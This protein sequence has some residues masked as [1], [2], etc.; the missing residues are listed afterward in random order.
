MYIVNSN[1][2]IQIQSCVLV[3]FSKVSLFFSMV[4][5]KKKLITT[6]TREHTATKSNMK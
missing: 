4:F 2:L 1:T 5:G 3:W 6:E